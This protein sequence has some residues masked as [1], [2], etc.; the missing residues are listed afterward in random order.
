MIIKVSCLAVYS[1]PRF[2]NLKINNMTTF[3]QDLRIQFDPDIH[4]IFGGNHSGKTTIVNSLKYGVFGLSSSNLPEGVEKRYFVSR[5]KEI[6]RKSLDINA[7]CS[8]NRRS[9]ATN[10]TV[11]SSGTAE[12]N[13][14][15][16]DDSG[17]FSNSPRNISREKEYYEALRN[18]AGDLNNNELDFI[19]QLLF[20]D[21]NRKPIL[22][23]D[24]LQSFVIRLLSSPEKRSELQKIELQIT[25]ME[26]R[27]NGLRQ[28]K[29]QRENKF[30]DSKRYF[31]FLEDKLDDLKELKLEES[32]KEITAIK[33]QLNDTKTVAAKN[34]EA[35][36]NELNRLRASLNKSEEIDNKIAELTKRLNVQRGELLGAFF[37]EATTDVY[38][39]GNYVYHK[40]QCPICFADI[41]SD[42]EVN[43]ANR[44]CPLCGKSE[45]SNVGSMTEIDLIISE[46]EREKESFEGLQNSTLQ[47]IAVS[48]KE[49][50]YLNKLL[51]E[52]HTLEYSLILKLDA[53]K[54]KEESLHSRD[55][56]KQQIQTFSKI[57][58]EN[59]EQMQKI[60]QEI[61]T[62]NLELSKF[63]D[64]A[65]N[66]KNEINFEIAKSLSK[67]KQNFFS[68][69]DLATNGEIKGDLSSELIPN[70]NGRPLFNSDTCS[71]FERTLMDIAFRIAL[72]STISEITGS[73][74]SLI[75]ETPDEVTD[76]SYIPFIAK[77]ISA[78]SK[79]ISII[80]TTYNSDLTTYLLKNYQKNERSRH[81][82]DLVSK[83]TLTQRKYYA[84]TIV[85]YSGLS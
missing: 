76:E 14:I 19:S 34:S 13:S 25:E 31:A 8:I 29:N 61:D 5:I 17:L 38:H 27:F 33:A 47:E 37:K 2:A 46:I 39:I 32:E 57:L 69:V 16:S 66:K 67:V 24:E 72:L 56:L 6:G 62:S 60:Q 48:Q 65:N 54:S 9:V 55:L 82:T 12:I 63:K 73:K 28:N 78:F 83:G 3:P 80:I 42:V 26:N 21:E 84:S 44:K 71:Q 22:W 35:L 11:F 1:L 74:P 49:M 30:L 18:E 23:T 53:L 4:V 77:A 58:E 43:I 50:V 51:S 64:L 59:Q 70:L 68:F 81:F 75:L 40:G 10:R 36:E 45:L 41:S 85:D 7:V 15:I 52:Q 20:A 79:Y